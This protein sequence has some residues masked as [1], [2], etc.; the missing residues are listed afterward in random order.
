MA[1]VNQELKK[2]VQADLKQV[3]PRK[4]KWSL[5]VRH[6][7]T[8][9]LTIRQAP[10]DLLQEFRNA[11]ASI[12]PMEGYY[13]LNPYHWDKLPHLS[14]K[15]RTVFAGIFE[16]MN[17]GNHDRSDVMTDYFDVGWYV[18]VQIGAWN[19]PFLHVVQPKRETSQEYLDQFPDPSD[20]QEMIDNGD[21]KKG[22]K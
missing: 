17:K 13:S 15:L 12:T 14:N 20:V 10:V 16:A 2:R 7:S 5:A 21:Y 8:L 18:D 3:M 6:H 11:G 19:S 9:V 1:Y 4:W 22:A